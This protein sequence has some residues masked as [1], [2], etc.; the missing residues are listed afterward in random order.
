MGTLMMLN[1]WGIIWRNQKI[2]LGM[3]EG[4]VAVAAANAVGVRAMCEALRAS[5]PQRRR[6]AAWR[7]SAA[8]ASS[9]RLGKTRRRTARAGEGRGR[10]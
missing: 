10:R 7:R 2:V 4:D 5:A 8:G 6:R 9:T 3:K 1:V